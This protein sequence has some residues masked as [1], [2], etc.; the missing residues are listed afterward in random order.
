MSSDI[1]P[2][3]SSDP[4]FCDSS[5]WGYLKDKV[6]NSNPWT[7][8]IQE[9]IRRG[10]ANIPTEPLLPVR[11]MY[12]CIG[13]AFAA[14][15]VICECSKNFISNVTGRQ[16]RCFIGK[17]RMRLAAR[18]A[19]VVVKRKTVNRSTKLRTS[20][21]LHEPWW[22]VA[23]LH[24]EVIPKQYWSAKDLYGKSEFAQ[25]LSNFNPNTIYTYL[26]LCGL[27]NFIIILK[28]ATAL[29]S[30]I[31]KIRLVGGGV[32]PGPLGTEATDWP[33]VAC[34]SWIWWWWNEDWQGKPKNSEKTRPSATLYITN[35]I[36]PNPGS[37][38]DRRGGKP[39][40][41]RLSYGAAQVNLR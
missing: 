15:T 12:T 35:P 25:S 19:A 33:I 40:T 31:L 2:A 41:N 39:A 22:D 28:E 5:F 32:Q 38:P 18:G 13:T 29:L 9:N 24:P 20:L 3:R 7:K 36:W 27:D 6:Y 14:P 21:D 1:W 8:D 11:R 23:L 4:N 34:R 37:N 10:I 26:Y 30:H 16:A 17:I